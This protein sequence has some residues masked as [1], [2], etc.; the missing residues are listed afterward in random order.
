M[1]RDPNQPQAILKDSRKALRLYRQA[2]FDRFDDL[3]TTDFW[4][5]MVEIMRKELDRAV[6]ANG[7]R[8]EFERV[9]KWLSEQGVTMS[10]GWDGDPIYTG[11]HRIRA[12]ADS[13]TQE[14]R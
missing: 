13:Y 8:A 9:T 12:L 5:R 7:R 6:K 2:N 3:C 10:Y 11:G 1:R 4:V 14:K